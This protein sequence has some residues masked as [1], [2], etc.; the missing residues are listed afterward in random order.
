MVHILQCDIYVSIWEMGKHQGSTE[1][2]PEDKVNC[3]SSRPFSET[4]RTVIPLTC[5]Q[6]SSTK[7]TWGTCENGQVLGPQ[8]YW[9]RD[10]GSGT[11]QS[12][13]MLILATIWEPLAG[14]RRVKDFVCQ[15]E[16]PSINR[17]IERGREGKEEGRGMKTREREGELLSFLWCR[18]VCSKPVF[19]G[20]DCGKH[21]ALLCHICQ[22]PWCKYCYHSLFQGT[23]VRLWNVEI[24][25]L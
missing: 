13:V 22:L 20:V 8:T 5:P 16:V 18:G 11:Q 25:I 3:E 21:E 4:P 1:L 23:N 9:I 15:R 14:S 19:R 2:L 17:E 10:S 12:V 24:G 6:T 7:V